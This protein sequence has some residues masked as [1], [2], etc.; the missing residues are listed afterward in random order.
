MN[1]GR[2]TDGLKTHV[3]S[4]CHGGPKYSQFKIFVKIENE[5]NYGNVLMVWLGFEPRLQTSIP[6]LITN[7][8][9]N[10]GTYLRLIYITMKT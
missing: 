9:T 6:N 5:I 4:L 1:P 7:S 8:K 2:W 10:S 3:N